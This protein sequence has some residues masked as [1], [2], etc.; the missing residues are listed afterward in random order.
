MFRIRLL[1]YLSR[2]DDDRNTKNCPVLSFKSVPVYNADSLDPPSEIQLHN[3]DL[4]SGYNYMS[5][6]TGVTVPR[7]ERLNAF[8]FSSVPDRTEKRFDRNRVRFL[9]VIAFQYLSIA[10]A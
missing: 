1:F 8:K 10:V 5:G 4:I 3:I 9:F 6:N 2:G 7:A